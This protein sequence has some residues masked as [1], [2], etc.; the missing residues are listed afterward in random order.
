MTNGLSTSWKNWEKGRRHIQSH[1]K[2][3]QCA[4]S[5]LG[6][7]LEVVK[8]MTDEKKEGKNYVVGSYSDLGKT[9]RTAAGGYF[10]RTN[11]LPI[12]KPNPNY[13]SVIVLF[14]SMY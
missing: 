12:T 2:A 4:A 1:T 5:H 6:P 11:A 8:L 13:T 7:L 3:D 9:L 14:C 10:Y